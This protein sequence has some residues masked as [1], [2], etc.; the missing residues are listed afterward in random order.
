[1]KLIKTIGVLILVS[2]SL[3]CITVEDSISSSPTGSKVEIY[4]QIDEKSAAFDILEIQVKIGNKTIN[5]FNKPNFVGYASETNGEVEVTFVVNV[6]GKDWYGKKVSARDLINLKFPHGE[7]ILITLELYYEDETLRIKDETEKSGIIGEKIPDDVFMS[8]EEALVKEIQRVYGEVPNKVKEELKINKKIREE[9]LSKYSE[10]GTLTYLRSYRDS[11]YAIR[12]FG[13]LAK[14][15]GLSMLDIKAFNL[16]LKANNEY[17]SRYPSPQKDFS[18]VIFS[19][20]SPYYSPIRI[21][22]ALNTS[23]PFLY[24]RGRGLSYYPVSAIHWA[25]IYFK[26]GNYEIALQFLNNL[27]EFIYFG[28]YNTKDYALF[29]NYFHFENSSIP[30]VSG[31]AQGMGAGLYAKAYQITKNETYLKIAKLLLDSFDLPLK[32]NGFVSNTKYGPWYLEY[33][34]NSN[35]LVLNGHIIALQGLYYYWEITKDEKAWQLFQAGVESTKKALPIFDTNSWSKYSNIHGDA[36]EFYHRLHIQ[37]LKWL[38]DV[39]GDEYFLNYARKWNNYL[40][41]RGLPP[42]DLG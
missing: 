10:T 8:S 27:Q 22:G 6:N 35:E 3:G 30:W 16:T 29:L 24:Y 1:M 15:K 32:K 39:T 34:Y 5:D 2:L 9:F 25:E 38:Y 19:E 17:Y 18:V 41:Y 20:N 7:K 23:L 12:A 33:N 36:S 14:W 31:Y 42:E 11:F 26:R 40:I 13:E 21:K 28:N 4:V 37:L